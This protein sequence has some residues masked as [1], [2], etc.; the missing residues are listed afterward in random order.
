M[1]F[2]TVLA[3]MPDLL[4]KALAE[5]IADEHG[6]CR[7]C[8]ADDGTTTPWPCAMRLLADEAS[9]MAAAAAPA[10]AEQPTVISDQW[11]PIADR[12]AFRRNRYQ[13]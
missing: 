12:R 10:P 11:D 9:T 6:H 3:A 7:E 5:H 1:S 8:R 13:L 4:A 2:A